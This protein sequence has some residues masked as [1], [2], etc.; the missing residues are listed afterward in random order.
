MTNP[1]R[2]VGELPDDTDLNGLNAWAGHL[3]N[4][5][6]D[7]LVGIVYLDRRKLMFDDDK[8]EVIPYARVVAVEVLGTALEASERY[9]EVLAAFLASHA[10][11][12]NREPLPFDE[13][14]PKPATPTLLQLTDGIDIEAAMAAADTACCSVCGHPVREHEPDSDRHCL[15]VFDKTGELC[16]CSGYDDWVVD[17]EIVDDPDDERDGDD[18]A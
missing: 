14:D 9:P 2:L 8:A 4:H 12:T 16:S 10:R 18:D 6:H 5:P 15:F 13:P 17:A 11:R 1:V 3:R 7:Q